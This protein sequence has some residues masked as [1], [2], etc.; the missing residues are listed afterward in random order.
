MDLKQ[1]LDVLK[2]VQNGQSD[3]GLSK[4]FESFQDLIELQ[5]DYQAKVSQGKRITKED[6]QSVFKRMSESIAQLQKEYGAFCEKM[7]KSPEEMKAYFSD[8]KNF[9]PEAWEELNKFSQAFGI[10]QG[11]S[12]VQGKKKGS[13]K[14][15][16]WAS[17]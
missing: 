17:I 7:G 14:F 16:K 6:L 2:T 9:T 4:L 5:I 12:A 15:S 10:E 8:P 11:S 1:M 3:E 13:K